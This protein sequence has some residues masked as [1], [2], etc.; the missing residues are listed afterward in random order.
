[1]R[2]EQAAYPVLRYGLLT[3]LGMF[4]AV[5][6]RL[7]DHSRLLTCTACRTRRIHVPRPGRISASSNCAPMA[8]T[9]IATSRAACEIHRAAQDDHGSHCAKLGEHALGLGAGPVSGV[10]SGR[11]RAPVLQRVPLRIRV[12]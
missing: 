9:I 3:A 4:P 11:F 7:A 8:G 2:S 10:R 12:Q 1:M 5:P 6:R